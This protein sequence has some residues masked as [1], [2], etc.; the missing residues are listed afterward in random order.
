METPHPRSSIKVVTSDDKTFC[1]TSDQLRDILFFVPLIE[2]DRLFAEPSRVVRLVDVCSE[3]FQTLL[4][5][6]SCSKAVADDILSQ[7][8]L[9][10]Q[11]KL[12]QTADYLCANKALRRCTDV[13]N[14]K[15][16]SFTAEQLCQAFGA[17]LSAEETLLLLERY[18]W[19]A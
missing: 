16:D 7:L 18:P 5:L 11:F 2:D 15:L 19:I 3:H 1:P 6:S 14:A 9:S 4:R 10:D 17:T 8:D 13:I 12:L